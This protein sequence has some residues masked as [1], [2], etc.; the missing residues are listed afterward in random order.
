MFN[1]KNIK[2][3][4][5]SLIAICMVVAMTYQSGLAGELRGKDF[6]RLGTVSTME[7]TLVKL[8]AQEWAL[9]VGDTRYDLHMGPSAFRDYH[10][11]ELKEGGSARVQ[12]YV[13]NTDVS[14]MDIETEGQSIVLRDGS[15]RP[16]WAGSSFSKRNSRPAD[17]KGFAGIDDVP[18]MK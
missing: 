14:V 15:G 2:M 13:Y 8:N 17:A 18:V 9:Q 16:A 4:V 10:Q 6:V 11:F 3:Y 1:R 5:V 12:G 7:G